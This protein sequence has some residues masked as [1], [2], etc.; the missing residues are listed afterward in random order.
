MNGLFRRQFLEVFGRF[1]VKVRFAAV[2]AQFDLLS[3]VDK[4]VG[5]PMVE[6]FVRHDAGFQR[7][8]LCRRCGGGGGGS[9]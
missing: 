5:L 7:V 1:F 9:R 8:R 2:A 6:R 4:G 3:V